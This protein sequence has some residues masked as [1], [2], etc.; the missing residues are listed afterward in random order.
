MIELLVDQ[1]FNEDIVDGLTR[2]DATLEFT[3]A[4]HVGLDAAADEMILEWCAAHGLVLLTHDRASQRRP[5]DGNRGR[6]TGKTRGER[7]GTSGEGRGT[8]GAG[9]G[10]DK[11][12]RRRPSGPLKQRM[13]THK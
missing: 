3:Y 4:R 12:K 9:R 1:K 10:G 6:G 11:A 7:R 8:S 5:S 13:P 2:R